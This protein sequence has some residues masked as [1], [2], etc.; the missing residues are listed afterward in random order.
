MI[1][2]K[3][4]ASTTASPCYAFTLGLTPA[5]FVWN[6]SISTAQHRRVTHIWGLYRAQGP[7]LQPWKQW[8][9]PGCSAVPSL[10]S[11]DKR[12]LHYLQSCF[13]PSFSAWWGKLGDVCIALHGT[14]NIHPMFH[15][16]SSSP[17][18]GTQCPEPGKVPGKVPG[19]LQGKT[20]FHHTCQ[21]CG[22]SAALARRGNLR[23]YIAAHSSA[24]PFPSGVCTY[25]G[26]MPCSHLGWGE[27]HGTLCGTMCLN[28]LL[29]LCHKPVFCPIPQQW[30]Q[31]RGYIPEGLC[32]LQDNQAQVQVDRRVFNV[33]VKVK[34]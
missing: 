22:S 20:A 7:S 25:P 30:S 3:P 5:Y 9:F 10:I 2:E 11:G 12:R 19:K 6:L 1:P 17:H 24:S 23:K 4:F 33:K 28:A 27:L 16:V 15:C 32:Y 34:K 29:F 31:V 8:Y 21:I 18:H 26:P 14:A 13:L